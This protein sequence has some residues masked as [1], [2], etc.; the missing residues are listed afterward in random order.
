MRT[1][2]ALREATGLT[3]RQLARKVLVRPEQIMA[4]ERGTAAPVGREVGWLALAVG[5]S[6]AGIRAALAL[7]AA[8]GGD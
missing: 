1:L 6:P 8:Q 5:A 4:W 3:E 7:Q 2:R